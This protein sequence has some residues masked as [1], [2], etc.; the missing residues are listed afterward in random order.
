M[1][2]KDCHRGREG[3]RKGTARDVRQPLHERRG[4][5][6]GDRTDVEREGGAGGREGGG[7]HFRPYGAGLLDI[8]E[9]CAGV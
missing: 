1:D 6:E 7:G 2:G 9:G 5:G 8:A 4:R 3:G